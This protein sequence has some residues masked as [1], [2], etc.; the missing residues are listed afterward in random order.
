M[1]VGSTNGVRVARGR[2]TGAT[3][4]GLPVVAALVLLLP[5]GAAQAAGPGETT[6]DGSLV[7]VAVDAPPAER[8]SGDGIRTMVRVGA[9]VVELPDDVEVAGATGTP[10]EMTVR[11]E[12][13][14]AAAELLDE[15]AVPEATDQAQVVSAVA[16]PVAATTLAGTTSSVLGAHTLTVLP[17]YTGAS[18]PAD[19]PTAADLTSV[20]GTTAQYWAGQSAGR[21]TIAPTVRDWQ[22]IQDPGSC[23]VNAIIASAMAVNGITEQPSGRNHVAVYFPTRDDCGGW[24]GLAIIGGNEIWATGAA[25][26]DVF[27][28]EFGHNLGLGHAN[29]AVCGTA[30]LTFPL[31]SCQLFEYGDGID[32]MGYADVGVP[33]GSL[34]SGLA[35]ALGLAVVSRPASGSTTTVDLAPLSQTTALRSV[36]IPVN[37]G[38]I[39][40]DYRPSVAPD[41]RVPEWAGVQVHYRISDPY[42][43]APTT[44]LLDMQP[45]SHF[46]E[47]ALPVGRTWV[48]PGTGRSV[49]VV[50]TGTAARITVGPVSSSA[51]LASYVRRVYLDLFDREVDA[52]GLAT[53]TAALAAG[54]PRVAVA[55]AITGSTEYRSRLIQESYQRYLGRAAE[56]AGLAY[57]LGQMRAGR[58]I[59]EMETGFLASDEYY[60]AAGRDPGTWVRRLYLDV[61]GRAPS[62]A[63]VGYWVAQQ[64]GRGRYAVAQGF[65]LSTEHLTTVV[66]GYYLDLLGRHIDPTGRATWVSQ[67]QRG[68][69]LEEIIGSI[70]ASAE[71]YAKV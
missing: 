40:V 59:V 54:T 58:R 52:G 36:A 50:A 23:D 13:P 25:L 57:W 27:S 15:V 64:G 56:P 8:T 45:S 44:Y 53:W 39:Y 21:I 70:V 62:T 37:G 65:L 60:N 42:S 67:I 29:A 4:R 14:M 26:P 17:V 24:V 2:L 68:H 6:V 19:E 71:Y 35:D 30:S 33:T 9:T 47:V 55:N 20:L 43:G 38:T 28:H 34:N 32:V 5:S 10:I 69:R 11:T 63:E 3:V 12:R 46:T 49:T 41:V 7:Q 61:L 16:Q 22:Q 31:S 1:P 48:V 66:D 18:L 51:Q